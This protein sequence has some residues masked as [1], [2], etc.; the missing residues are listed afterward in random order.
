MFF[1]H[2]FGDNLLIVHLLN[3]IVVYPY[4]LH[5][6]SLV[7]MMEALVDGLVF[8]PSILSFLSCLN[9]KDLWPS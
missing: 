5:I 2:S 7:Y 4:L 8:I 9:W 3:T 1:K 6:V